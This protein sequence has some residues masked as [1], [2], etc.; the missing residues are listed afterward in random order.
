VI[1]DITDCGKEFMQPQTHSIFHINNII[2][3]KNVFITIFSYIFIYKVFQVKWTTYYKYKYFK[4]N[5]LLFIF[6]VNI[7]L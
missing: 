3:K 1:N 2:H 7:I 6:T 4:I 5:E